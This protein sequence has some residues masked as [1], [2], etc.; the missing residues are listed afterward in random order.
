M[1]K[2]TF[3]LEGRPAKIKLINRSTDA[4]GYWKILL[5]DMVIL[6]DHRGHRGRLYGKNLFWLDSDSRAPKGQTYDVPPQIHE[7]YVV[8]GDPKKIGNSRAT[9]GGIANKC[10]NL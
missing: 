7:R 1:K 6:Q 9:D 10:I 4:W 3:H 5:D 8:I 2:K